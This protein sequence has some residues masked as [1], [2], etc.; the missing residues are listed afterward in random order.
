MNDETKAAAGETAAKTDGAEATNQSSAS[1][2]T[3]EISQELEDEIMRSF[4]AKYRLPEPPLLRDETFEEREESL[5]KSAF[6]VVSTSRG[7]TFEEREEREA[8]VKADMKKDWIW[9]SRGS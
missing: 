1:E 5:I 2:E 9:A 6:L 3:F 8:A 4:I 7:E